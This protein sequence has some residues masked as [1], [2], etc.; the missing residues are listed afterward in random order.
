MRFMN[1]NML[2]ITLNILAPTNDV[3]SITSCNCSYQH[4]S[5]FNKLD[6]TFDKLGKDCWTSMMLN[7]LLNYQH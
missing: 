3:S 4:V 5:L 7:V 1:F 2:S 6:H